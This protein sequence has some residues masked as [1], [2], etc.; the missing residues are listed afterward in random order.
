MWLCVVGN[1]KNVLIVGSSQSNDFEIA[2]E[3]LGHECVS[4]F[5]SW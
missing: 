3:L 1:A 4:R 2:N 5:S